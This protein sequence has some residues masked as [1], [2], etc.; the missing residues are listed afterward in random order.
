M[1]AGR[2]A[3]AELVRESAIFAIAE[4]RNTHTLRTYLFGWLLRLVLQTMFF[5]LIAG[6][7]GTAESVQ[8]VLV[9]NA[10]VL[11]CL[12]SMIV[13]L[14]MA[15]ERSTGTLPL[16]AASPTSHVPVYLGRG[17]HWMASGMTSSVLTFVALPFVMGVPLPWPQAVLAV[18]IIAVTCVTSYCLG[19]FLGSLGLRFMSVTWLL[20]NLGY[21]P[22]MAFCGVN[23]P[24]SFWPAP[25]RALAEILPVTHGLL[26]IRG[27]LA[28]HSVTSILS[29]VALELAVGAGWLLVA[30][31]S[32]DRTVR[33]GIRTGSLE[34]GG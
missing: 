6:Y 20:L 7:V 23:V 14:M 28:G 17:L 3:T 4:M 31:V 27:V 10:V 30:S 5:A 32:I 8:Y 21:L 25:V 1:S 22:V 15:Q 29:E 24:T 12:E 34:F 2:A 9:G 19:C 16:L 33:H 11:G 18:P 13:V 26:A